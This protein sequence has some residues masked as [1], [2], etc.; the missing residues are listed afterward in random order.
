[1][2]SHRTHVYMIWHA[3]NLGEQDFANLLY[4]A[5]DITRER[6]IEKPATNASMSGLRNKMPYFFAVVRRELEEI[7]VD[8]PEPG[9]Q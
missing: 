8:L 5:R 2:H 4:V 3:S 1:M 7:G 9:H 6:R